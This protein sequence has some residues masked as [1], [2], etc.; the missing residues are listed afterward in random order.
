[1]AKKEGRVSANER[2]NGPWLLYPSLSAFNSVL[3]RLPAFLQAGSAPFRINPRR[4]VTVFP[5]KP[6]SLSRLISRPRSGPHWEVPLCR[7][8]NTGR[9]EPPLKRVLPLLQ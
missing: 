7:G 8:L 1:M 9:P 6:S 4:G 3:G 5:A 2:A